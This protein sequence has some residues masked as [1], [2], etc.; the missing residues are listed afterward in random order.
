MHIP[1]EHNQVADA[2]LHYYEFNLLTDLCDKQDL[3]NMDQKLNPEGDTLPIECAEAN[4]MNTNSSKL[5]ATVLP[6]LED[7]DNVLA[8]ES[9]A[10]GVPLKVR[11][12][13]DID[14]RQVFTPASIN[15]TL[16]MRVLQDVKAHLHF[17][18]KDKLLWTKNS[19]G[20]SVV[21]C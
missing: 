8:I 12:K 3:V 17:A 19:L 11:V 20:H 4:A 14:L 9:G 1:G 2:L 7:I 13:T 21:C 5:E 15:N 16:C 18:L 10:D 6:Q